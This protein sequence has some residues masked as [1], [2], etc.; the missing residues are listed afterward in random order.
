M[1]GYIE[2]DEATKTATFTPDTVYVANA[3]LELVV[4]STVT[5]LA[6]NPVSG[7][8]TTAFTTGPLDEPHVRDPF[9]PNQ[10]IAEATE[11]EFGPY[12]R[13]L[14]LWGDE[15]D[16]FEFTVANT[17]GV[18]VSTPIQYAD[19]SPWLMKFLRADGGEYARGSWSQVVANNFGSLQFTFAPGTYYVSIGDTA[20]PGFAVYSIRLFEWERCVDDPY[21]DNDF[22]DEAYPLAPG[23][24]T[25][26]RCCYLDQDFYAID[27]RGRR[28]ADRGPGLGLDVRRLV[29]APGP[30]G[31]DGAGVSAGM[32]PDPLRDGGRAEREPT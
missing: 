32:A 10:T 22:L 13:T 30:D 8:R 12:Y 16:V 23:T 7:D 29:Q 2:Y 24:Y 5:D 20:M 4:A 17:T 14:S 9:Y 25:D 1:G 28:D 3:D 15:R 6:G 19:H 31:R 18:L 21:E 27:V 26:M 11:I